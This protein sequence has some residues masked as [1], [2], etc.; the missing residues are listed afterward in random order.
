M[1]RQCIS[2][3]VSLLWSSLKIGYKLASGGCQL[4]GL[5]MPVVTIFGSSK[6]D[7]KSEFA[8]QAYELA[9][10]FV[11]HDIS[12]V[13]G[14]G[15]G[16]MAAASSGA[17]D[18]QE[19]DVVRTLGV[20]V[21]GANADYAESA[22]ELIEVD[23]FF[24]RK[25]LLMRYSIGYVFFPGGIG[26]MDELFDLLNLL[27]HHKIP[28]LPIVLFGTSYW[29]PLVEWFANAKR[30][31][32]IDDRLTHLFIV[33]DDLDETFNHLYNVCRAYQHD[34]HE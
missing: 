29:Q 32:M 4:S 27:K 24:M 25:W 14:G 34:D 1:R 33:S 3:G 11:S 30:M 18:A 31:G 15:P 8:R 16:I 26:T 23:H 10:R 12:V 2:A 20:A 17:L 5:P 28:G 6:V 19:D 22:G 7:K 13:T 21:S 9:H